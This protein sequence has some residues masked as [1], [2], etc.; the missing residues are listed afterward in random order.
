MYVDISRKSQQTIGFPGTSS[1]EKRKRP[2]YERQ[3]CMGMIMMVPV[4]QIPADDGLACV[5]YKDCYDGHIAIPEDRIGQ[6]IYSN[7]KQYFGE[8]IHSEEDEFQMAEYSLDYCQKNE[9]EG[10]IMRASRYHGII[11]VKFRMKIAL[12][13][14]DLN[15]MI[16]YAKLI[17]FI[18]KVRQCDERA[19]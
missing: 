13:H 10:Y 3:H 18:E 6:M 7:E 12:E 5:K 9:V 8:H 11:G 1:Q 19:Y 4:N 2:E 15:R 17:A 14:G 16:P